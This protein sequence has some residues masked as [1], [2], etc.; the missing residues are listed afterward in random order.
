MKATR[1]E[2]GAW[3]VDKPDDLMKWAWKWDGEEAVIIDKENS[4]YYCAREEDEVKFREA[5]AAEGKR[6]NKR[7]ALPFSAIPL[8]VD[9]PDHTQ[10][11]GW[12]E[13][14]QFLCSEKATC[15]GE[16]CSS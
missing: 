14:K 1:K 11:V 10:S 3:V 16:Q 2:N 6:D 12:C 5:W 9:C 13:G 7:R 15:K 4:T 8:P